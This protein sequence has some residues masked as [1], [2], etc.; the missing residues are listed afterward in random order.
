MLEEINGFWIT[1]KINYPFGRGINF[2]ILIDD[3]TSIVNKL[4]K[5]NIPLYRDI[6]ESCYDINETVITEREILVQAPDGYL[7]RFSELISCLSPFH[8][9]LRYVCR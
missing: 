1:D 8:F 2:Q 3:V 9:E 7:L 4:K 6:F 5:N